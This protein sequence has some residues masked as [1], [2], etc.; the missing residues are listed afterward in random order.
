MRR[1]SCD[2]PRAA[3]HIG[4]GKEGNQ[5]PK[6]LAIPRND[7]ISLVKRTEKDWIRCFLPKVMAFWVG[8]MVSPK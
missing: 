4:A 2:G 6:G 1:G 7:K 3:H 8:I 5:E